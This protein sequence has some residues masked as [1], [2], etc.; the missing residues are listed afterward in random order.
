MRLLAFGVCWLLAQTALAEDT[1]F[2]EETVIT[3]NQEL[4]KVLYILPWRDMDT[5]LLPQRDFEFS[6]QSVLVPVY[7]DEHRLEIGFRQTLV[8]ARNKIQSEPTVS[9]S[10]SNNNSIS[11]DDN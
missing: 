10:N 11:N 3:G 2:L 5:A 7:P 1:I 8:E 4:P 6:S 9:I